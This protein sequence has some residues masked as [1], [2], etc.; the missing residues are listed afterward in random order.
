MR[1]QQ[2]LPPLGESSDVLLFNPLVM[3][4]FKAVCVH[5]DL[6]DLMVFMYLCIFKVL[7]TSLSKHF[8]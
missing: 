4:T 7:S 6:L 1:V 3:P 2:E 8:P 5:G